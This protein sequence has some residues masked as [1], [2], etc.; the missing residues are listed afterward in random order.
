M[1][2]CLAA[3]MI[4]QYKGT[5]PN[6]VKKYRDIDDL[7]NFAREYVV[8]ILTTKKWSEIKHYQKIK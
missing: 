1:R 8:N 4:A 6:R 5:I 7:G 2:I 3:S